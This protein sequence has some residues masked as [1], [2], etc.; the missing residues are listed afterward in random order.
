MA[1]QNLSRHQQ[2]IVKR[3][4]E[5]HETIQTNKLSELVSELWLAE[6]EA[7]QAKLWGRAQTALMRLNLDP[8]KVADVVNRRDLKAL[9]TLVSQADAGRA[10]GTGTRGATPGAKQGKWVGTGPEPKQAGADSVS[11]GRTIAQARAEQ[12]AAGGFDSLDEPNL[13]RALRRFRDKLKRLRREAE[14]KPGS[15]APITAI[16]PP[17]AFPTAVWDKLVERNRLHRAG[18]GLLELPED[19]A[20]RTRR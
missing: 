9:A 18:H 6:G 3:Y 12:A 16:T 1:K 14:A 7:Q 2:G 20:K 5:H 13:K 17:D 4:Y 11:D 19:A 15:R 8:R 10:P